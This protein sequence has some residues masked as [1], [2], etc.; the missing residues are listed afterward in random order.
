MPTIEQV[1]RTLERIFEEESCVASTQIRNNGIEVVV[2]IY[3]VCGACG[4]YGSCELDYDS[5]TK[6]YPFVD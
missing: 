3:Y 5:E 1:Q 6:F 4:E 2:R